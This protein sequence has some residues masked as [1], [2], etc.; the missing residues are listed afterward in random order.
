MLKCIHVRKLHLAA[1]SIAA[2]ALTGNIAVASL[3]SKSNPYQTEPSDPYSIPFPMPGV[4]PP[5]QS[6]HMIVV[7]VVKPEDACGCVCDCRTGEPF[8]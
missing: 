2:V 4:L 6:G 7:P 5:H 1:A 8:F 3:L